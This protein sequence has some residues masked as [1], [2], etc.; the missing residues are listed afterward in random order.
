MRNGWRIEAKFN[1]ILPKQY[2]PLLKLI[3]SYFDGVGIIGSHGN[4]TNRISYTV[5]TLEDLTN[6][7]IHFDSYPLITHQKV[8]YELFKRVIEIMKDRRHLTFEGLQ[9]IVNILY[10]VNEYNLSYELKAAFLPDGNNITVHAAAK[11]TVTD[12]KIPDPHWVSGFISGVGSFSIRVRKSS[13]SSTGARVELKFGL[14]HNI[15]DVKVIKSLVNFLRCG[16]VSS[17]SKE[18]LISFNV[19]KFFDL[20]YI[21]TPFLIKYPIYGK[22]WARRADFGYFCKVLVIIKKKEHL[23][24]PPRGA[25]LKEI[26]KIRD[27]MKRGDEI[28]EECDNRFKEFFEILSYKGVYR[29][30]ELIKGKA[31][32]TERRLYWSTLLRDVVPLHK[33]TTNNASDI[34]INSNLLNPWFITG[35]TDAEGSFMVLICKG[36]RY[37]TGWQVSIRFSIGLHKKDLALLKLIQYYFG[38][39]GLIEQREMCSWRVTR[40]EHLTNIIIPHFLKYPLITQK[41]ADFELFK[42]VV[43]LMN[44]KKHLTY[45]GLQEIVNLKYSI[46]L[47]LSNEL[48]QAF[49]NTIPS[50]RPLVRKE[51]IPNPN[52]LSGFT[53]GD[54]NF[55]VAINKS[56]TCKVGF[57]VQLRFNLYQHVRDAELILNISKYLGCGNVYADGDRLKVFIVH[58]LDDIVEIIIPIFKMYPIFGIKAQDF[59]DFCKVSELIKKGEHLNAD[60]F[61]QILK[62]RSSMNKGRKLVLPQPEDYQHHRCGKGRLYMY[63]KDKTILYHFTENVKEFSEYLKIYKSTLYKHLTNGTY[64]LNK[65]SFSEEFSDNVLNFHNLSL[66]ELNLML[67]KDREKFRRKIKD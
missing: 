18:K 66:P 58:K 46:N 2:L 14:T 65:Y 63:N 51:E 20:I 56:S 5:Y 59:T 67:T 37:R 24:A 26:I 11:P 27:C 34:L 15:R 54:G 38:G 6:I 13:T 4:N 49:P 41:K 1:F 22:N 7:L 47:G 62:I 60:G 29:D 55:S 10:S 35:F 57:S 32:K 25:G 61:S 64:Y 50:L 17:I 39:I 42:R 28:G 3:Q 36:P 16:N 44:C 40:L 9:E 53:S 52:W 31:M 43:D 33:E 23:T 30:D 45:E 48:T 12:K 19:T 8:R 21:F